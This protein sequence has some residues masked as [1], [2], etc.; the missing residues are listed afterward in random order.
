[1]GVI[2]QLAG[3]RRPEL[4]RNVSSEP[5]FGRDLYAALASAKVVIN[6]AI[7]M[8]GGGRGNMRCFETMGAGALLVSGAGDY[9]PGMAA[10]DTMLTYT[11]AEDARG[12]LE[13]A[14]ANANRS[15]TIARKGQEMVR[16]RYSKAEQFRR[17]TELA[18]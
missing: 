5:V 16:G 2:P 17:F 18:A 14:V 1:M 4:I 10:P 6:C 11:S 12:R 15:A 7:D 8:A 13:E 9:P 3:H